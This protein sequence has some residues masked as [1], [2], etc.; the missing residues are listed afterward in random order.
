VT[1]DALGAELARELEARERLEW[2]KHGREGNFYPS[3]FFL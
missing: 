2:R 3:P 1:A